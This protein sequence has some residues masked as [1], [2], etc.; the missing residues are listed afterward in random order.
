MSISSTQI[1]AHYERFIGLVKQDSRATE[2]LKMYDAFEQELVSAPASGK[3]HFHNCF[4]GGYIDHVLRVID[5]S[6]ELTALYK[7]LGGVVDYTKQEVVF[8]AMHH[9]L[10]KLGSTDGSYYVDQTSDWHRD[11]LG[12]MYTHNTDIGFMKVPDRALFV[13]QQFNVPITEKEWY[14]IKLSDG[15]Y[16][17]SNKAYLINYTHKHPIRTALAHIIHQA[18]SMASHVENDAI[19]K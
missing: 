12:E 8:A 16:D 17:D 7:K 19:P 2:L 5:C 6:L 1:E 4:P 15:L 10:G 14:G 13:L 11:K 3:K 9:D 18:D